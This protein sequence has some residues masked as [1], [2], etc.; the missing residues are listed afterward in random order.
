MVNTNLVNKGNGDVIPLIQHGQLFPGKMS[1][2][3]GSLSLLTRPPLTRM[4]NC[5]MWAPCTSDVPDGID[6]IA[7]LLSLRRFG[8]RFT[9]SYSS[10]I[11]DNKQ[12]FGGYFFLLLLTQCFSPDP[13]W[14]ST[15][16]LIVMALFEG[17]VTSFSLVT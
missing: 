4:G 9:H 17:Y 12:K 5:S 11:D 16:T 6:A 15:L 2:A 13:L 8:S 3:L 7:T 1:F 14:C 10:H